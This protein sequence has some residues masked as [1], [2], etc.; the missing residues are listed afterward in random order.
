M[1][2]SMNRNFEIKPPGLLHRN[3]IISGGT[4]GAKNFY[5]GT[6][7]DRICQQVNEEGFESES[8]TSHVFH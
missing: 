7:K 5:E 3:S 1:Q 4:M 2:E 6:D 8:E